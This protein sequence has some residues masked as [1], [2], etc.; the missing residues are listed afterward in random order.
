MLG[1]KA[2][3]SDEAKAAQREAARGGAYGAVKWGVAAA[4]LGGLGYAFSPVYRGLTVQ[5]KV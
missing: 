2:L 4:V 1:H 5:F 3:D